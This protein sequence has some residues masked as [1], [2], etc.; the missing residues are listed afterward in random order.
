MMLPFPL[1][2]TPNTMKHKLELSFESRKRKSLI[3]IK[4]IFFLKQWSSSYH[5]FGGQPLLLLLGTAL[6][7]WRRDASGTIQWH[8]QT[9][10]LSYT[11][12]SRNTALR[13][14]F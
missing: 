8:V 5:L 14:K 7:D 1:I 4:S 12:F 9:R 6:L 10:L 2:T 3:K 11:I 13:S